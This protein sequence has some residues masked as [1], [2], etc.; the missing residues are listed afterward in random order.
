MRAVHLQA[1]NIVQLVNC[2]TKPQ[3][4]SFNAP[5]SEHIDIVIAHRDPENLPGLA[6]HK[7]AK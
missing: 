3:Q 6:V 1:G 7:A 5:V 4:Q 2:I